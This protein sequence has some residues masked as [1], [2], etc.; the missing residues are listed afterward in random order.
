M[1]TGPDTCEESQM[2]SALSVSQFVPANGQPQTATKGT[3]FL[4]DKGNG[5]LTAAMRNATVPDERK[6]T[7][8]Q[9][10]SEMS[11]NGSIESMTEMV[12]RCQEVLKGTH[13]KKPLNETSVSDITPTEQKAASKVAP[14]RTS[15][16]C[17]MDEHMAQFSVGC[18]NECRGQI[19]LATL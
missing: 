1:A 18:M 3:T 14:N 10:K 13:T 5:S 17:N 2:R 8:T 19:R 12:K 11:E 4:E 6:K 7:E 9:I 16:Q 15:V